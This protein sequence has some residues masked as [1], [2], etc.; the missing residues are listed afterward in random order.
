MTRGK[1]AAKPAATVPAPDL[2]G[3]PI[4]E[5]ERRLKVARDLNQEL[6]IRRLEGRIA[7]VRDNK[8]EGVPAPKTPPID[9]ADRDKLVAQAYLRT[10]N[11]K[12]TE[13]EA[14]DSADPLAGA[15]EGAKGLRDLIWALL[16]TKEFA[17]NH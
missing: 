12:P 9:P 16:N 11:R 8:L 6:R 14:R 1:A 10:L 4:A 2:E 5:L 17:T 3:V 7:Y 15:G 13:A